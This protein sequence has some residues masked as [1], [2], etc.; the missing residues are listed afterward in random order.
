MKPY[1]IKPLVGYNVLVPHYSASPK[2][3]KSGVVQASCMPRWAVL[4]F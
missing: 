1:E 2:G 4:N 3:L